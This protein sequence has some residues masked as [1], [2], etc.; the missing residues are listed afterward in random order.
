MG[1]CSRQQVSTLLPAHFGK[2][3]PR[4]IGGLLA[5]HASRSGRE[6]IGPPNDTA[7]IVPKVFCKARESFRPTFGTLLP[8]YEGNFAAVIAR[9]S[10]SFRCPSGCRS[11]L[12]AGT[13]IASSGR[14]PSSHVCLPAPALHRTQDGVP[15][16]QVRPSAGNDGFIVLEEHHALW[17]Y[18]QRHE[19][20]STRLVFSSVSL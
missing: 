3:F 2:Q 7:R 4:Q 15:Q 8:P 16:V 9:R 20:G 17:I 10:S 14:I 5:Q 19:R 11:N 18:L 6:S 12:L 1:K 13:G